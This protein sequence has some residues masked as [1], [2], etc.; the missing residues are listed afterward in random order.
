MSTVNAVFAAS[1]TISVTIPVTTTS[2]LAAA[3]ATTSFS[4]DVAIE[5]ETFLEIFTEPI[6]FSAAPSILTSANI[7][8][9]VITVLADNLR[10]GILS[11][12]NAFTLKEATAEPSITS[13]SATAAFFASTI[14]AA[15]PCIVSLFIFTP[16]SNVITVPSPTLAAIVS[17]SYSPVTL[18]FPSFT[19]AA[20]IVFTSVDGVNGSSGVC[21]STGGVCVAPGVVELGTVGVGTSV[22]PGVVEL[23]TVG[24]GTSVAGICVAVASVTF[25]VNTAFLFE[26]SCAFTVIFAVPA[27]FAVTLP[28]EPTFATAFLF[29]V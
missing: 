13:T 25:T 3:S 5:T 19:S 23:G 15:P 28:F 24:V 21:V 22:A 11:F 9:A 20:V 10:V 7:T 29:E 27:F 8:I 1:T 12:A 16:S 6:F 14:Y 2:E 17:L 18:T 4:T 26:P